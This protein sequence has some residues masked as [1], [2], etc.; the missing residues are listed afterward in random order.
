MGTTIKAILNMERVSKS[1]FYPLVIRVIHNRRR[2]MF[3]SS[4]HLSSEQFN[5]VEEKVLWTEDSPYPKR[6]VDEMNRFI[7]TK[8]DELEKMI[9]RLQIEK[10]EGFSADDLLLRIQKQNQ[11]KY[12]YCYINKLVDAKVQSGQQGG[13]TLLVSCRNSLQRYTGTSLVTFGEINFRFVSEYINHL[14]SRNLTENSIR[15][16]LRNFRAIYKKAVREGIASNKKDPFRDIKM[17]GTPTVKRAVGKEVLRKI[18]EIDLS[19]NIPLEQAR[20][21]FLFSFYTR[22]M[23][24]VDMLYLQHKDIRDGYIFYVRNKTRQDFQVAIT[25]PV[26]ALI[27][28]YKSKSSYILPYLND[29]SDVSLYMQYRKALNIIN[30]RLKRVGRLVGIQSPLTTYVARHSW[31]TI[32]KSEGVSIA[33]ISEG[34][35]HTTEKTTQIYLKAMDHKKIDEANAHIVKL[36]D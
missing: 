10:K 21:L 14:R 33:T 18:A 15:M 12:L 17:S 25:K 36:L 11:N 20:D 5:K 30:I 29:K 4:Y 23:S 32:A 34:L 13:A 31:A 3:Y 24:L 1:G 8:K 35:G 22:G 6:K 27:D 7:R 19:S 28:K 16:Y 9:Y 26:Q 2:K